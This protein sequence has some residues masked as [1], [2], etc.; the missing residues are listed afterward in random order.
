[1]KSRTTR[2][3]FLRG[4]AAAAAG[5]I[6]L[7]DRRLAFGYSA[8]DKL[9]VAS[10]GVAGMGWG[11]LGNVSSENVVALCDVHGSRA[12]KAHEKHPQAK[13]YTDFRRMLDE[14]DK[15]ID[16]AVVSTPDHTHAVA[17][18]AAMKRGKHVYCEKPLTRT[19]K[20][21]RVMRETAVRHKV[22]TQMGNQGS[23]SEGVRR[24]VELMGAGAIGEVRAAHVWFGGGNGP[25]TPPTDKPPVP[26]DVAWDLWL[27]PAPYRPYH[28]AY[29]PAVWRHWRAFGS[30]AMGDMGCHTINIVFRALRLVELWSPD[31]AK[32]RPPRVVIRVRAE[33]SEV[34][35][36]GYPGWMRVEYDLPARDNMPPVK[37]TLYTGGKKPADTVMRGEAMTQWGSLLDGDKGA[38]FSNCPWNTRYELLP[39]KEFQ[40]FAGPDR[41]LPRGK[42]HHAEWIEACKGRGESFSSFQ[43]GGPLTELIQLGNA[44][45]LIGEPFE[46]DTLS[47]QVINLPEANRHL[48]REYRDGWSL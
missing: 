41:T 15:Q 42:G 45:V 14:M 11:N 23:A 20:E 34:D 17:A 10:I 30:G 24:S 1:M 38:L 48:H 6:L 25:K 16:A 4:S 33:A 19:V 21:A 27:G 43:I 40:G 7:R 29:M 5:V 22:V 3:A 35:A 47:G 13:R 32:P 31:P 44:A 39:K 26:P 37:L 46:F 9:N 2:R 12:T 18:V 8:N 36:E 28:S